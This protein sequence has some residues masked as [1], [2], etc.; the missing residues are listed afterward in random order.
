[1]DM[2]LIPKKN[3]QK[4][5]NKTKNMAATDYS[6]R[7]TLKQAF[8]NN[9]FKLFTDVCGGDPKEFANELYSKFTVEDFAYG[10]DMYYWGVIEYFN[11][12]VIPHKIEVYKAGMEF[13]NIPQLQHFFNESTKQ[14]FIKNLW[15]H[16]LSKFSAN[17]A[18]GYACYN[19]KT[20]S[21]KT[22]FE[23]S[24]HHHKMNNPHHP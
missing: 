3:N 18:F 19:Q 9:V 14:E 23:R 17:E 22:G 20:G 12:T 15:L 21:G 5:N 6:K 7:T 16:D 8:T 11:L 10:D 1:M 13:F 2:R 4:K 24:W